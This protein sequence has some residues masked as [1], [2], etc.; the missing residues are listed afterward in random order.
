VK[1]ID[2]PFM[3]IFIIGVV[4][5]NLF[6]PIPMLSRV[7]TPFLIFGGIPASWLFGRKFTAPDVSRRSIILVALFISCVLFGKCIK[8]NLSYDKESLDR[9]H[10]YKLFIQDYNGKK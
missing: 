6:Y 4:I 5:S 2:T 8:D 7:A 3:K 10:P 9:M 1:S